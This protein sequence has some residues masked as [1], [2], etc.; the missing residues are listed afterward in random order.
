MSEL[1]IAT[2]DSAQRDRLK[3]CFLEIYEQQDEQGKLRMA[4]E[5]ES[6]LNSDSE[7][8]GRILSCDDSWR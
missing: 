8:R 3:A 1:A 6:V 4:K 2:S 5:I 7:A